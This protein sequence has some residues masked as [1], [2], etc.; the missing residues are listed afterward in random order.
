MRVRTGRDRAGTRVFAPLAA[1][2]LT[3]AVFVAHGADAVAQTQAQRLKLLEQTVKELLARDEARERKMKAMEAELKR[4]R[5]GRGLAT[6]APKDKPEADDHAHDHAKKPDAGK[7]KMADDHAGHDHGQEADDHADEHAAEVWS[8]RVGDG[9]LRLKRLGLD[10][11]FAMGAGS[12]KPE[13]MEALFGG[14]H[15]PQRTGFTLQGVDLSAA[16]SFDPYFDAFFNVNFTVDGG[17]ETAI[18]LEEAWA[19][20]KWLGGALRFQGGHFYAPFGI[21]NRTHIHDWFWQTRPIAATRVFG[22]DGARG[23]GIQAEA[24][25]ASEGSFRSSLFVSMQN[26]RSIHLHGHGEEEGE[27]PHHTHDDTTGEAIP[28]EDDHADEEGETKGF[29]IA[30]RMANQVKASPQTS[31]TFGASA[32]FEPNPDGGDD[33]VSILGGDVAISHRLSSN[34]RLLLTAEYLHRTAKAA[35]HHEEEEGTG[36]GEDE[37]DEERIRV[38]DYGFYVQGLWITQ[39]GFGV[40][41]RYEQVDSRG[42]EAEEREADPMRGKRTRISP[43][44]LWQ[45]SEL[46]KLKFQYN[47]DRATF[48]QKHNVAH[49]VFMSVSW[50]FGLGAPDHAGHAH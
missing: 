40:G 12:A 36:N 15:D 28:E 32:M 11:D 1:T 8:A 21:V 16:G 9:V 44:L 7:E 42:G 39:G 20:S 47:Y 35:E 43:L 3:V 25:L 46:G 50:S 13:D 5:G 45:F 24:R 31:L 17:G 33:Q 6:V 23:L 14:H 34:D 27:F 29:G 10:V 22:A 38:R 37:H 30:I 26:R 48:L 2:L 4:L 41:M 49:S 19:R 18:E